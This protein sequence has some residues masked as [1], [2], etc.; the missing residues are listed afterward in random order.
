M[1]VEYQ[2]RLNERKFANWERLSNGGRKYWLEVV[3]RHGWKAKYVKEV[4]D[5]EK[6]L[7]FYQEIYNEY[8]ILVEIH[9]KFPED[10]GHKKVEGEHQ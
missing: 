6:T 5:Q 4:S 9:E 1:N 10:R 7:K 2:R 3:G 8:G